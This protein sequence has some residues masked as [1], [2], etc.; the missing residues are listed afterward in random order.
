MKIILASNNNGKLNEFTDLL[1]PFGFDIIPQNKVYDKDIEENGK[2]FKE[3]AFIKANTLYKKTKL[4]TIADDSGLMVDAL[5]GLPGIHSARFASNGNKNSTDDEN[6]D[7]LLFEMKDKK[8]RK[9]KFV[10]VICYID[11]DGNS[12]Y[13][14]GVCHG[15][16]SYKREGTNGFGY[17]S[18]FLYNN[19]SFATFTKAQKNQVS[20]RKAALC[21]FIE[22]LR[23]EKNVKF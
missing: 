14:E 8:N 1:S 4:P 22:Y 21:K 23:G 15:E 19:K 7:K 18:V 12:H 11:K 5:S 16:I 2:T 6:I 10:C 3:N 17:D 13:F 9:A 20:H